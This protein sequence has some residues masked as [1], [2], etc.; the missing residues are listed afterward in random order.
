M[1]AKRSSDAVAVFRRYV[2][3]FQTLDPR[4]VVPFYGEPALMITPMGVLRCPT[5]PQ[6]SESTGR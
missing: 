3:A 5:A 2:Q 1:H 6:S 4:A